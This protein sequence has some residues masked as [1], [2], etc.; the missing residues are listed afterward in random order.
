MT[1]S[2]SVA[3]AE[4]QQAIDE[5]H[6]RSQRESWRVAGVSSQLLSMVR[7]G[8]DDASLVT[9][10]Q[11]TL[12][13]PALISQESCRSFEAL[14]SGQVP[15]GYHEAKTNPCSSGR[16]M[17]ESN[18]KFSSRKSPLSMGQKRQDKEIQR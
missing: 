13:I 18:R 5:T 17:L 14:R 6:W 1:C 4:G 9:N 11:D 12:G 2:P 10:E 15:S 7:A 16:S 3:D 8:P